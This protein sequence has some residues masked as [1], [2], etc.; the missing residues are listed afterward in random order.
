MS[1][2]I[3]LY[4]QN[5]DQASPGTYVTQLNTAYLSNVRALALKT[6]TFVNNLPNIFT[7]GD[8]QNNEFLYEIDGTPFTATVAVEGYYT[9]QEVIALLVLAIQAQLDISSPGDVISA[10]IESYSGKVSFLNTGVA[11]MTYLG[12][13]GLLNQLLGNT[14]DSPPVPADD[15]HV[16]GSLPD[17]IGLKSATVSIKSKS[18]KTI[19][20]RSSQKMIWTNSLG[21]VPCN[22]SFGQLQTWEQQDLDASRLTFDQP[23]DLTVIQFK[24]RGDDGKILLDQTEHLAIEL[25]VWTT[26]Q[27]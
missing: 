27:N 17:L 23:E 24:I 4:A 10:Q 18:P 5:A 26:V 2:L 13:T 21:M 19:L 20:N 3:A 11:V 12:S 14:E 9:A 6:V 1:K 15:L 16:F 7:A 22:V 8:R 25:K